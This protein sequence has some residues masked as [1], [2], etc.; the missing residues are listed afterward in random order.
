MWRRKPVVETDSYVIIP[1]NTAF[2]ELVQVA[3]HRLG[4]P[5]ESTSAA[6]GSVVIKNWKPLSFEKIAE[7]PTVTVGDILGELTTVATLRIQ[8]YRARPSILS[9]IK[10]KLL[11][12]LLA[13]SHGLLMS[14][15]CPLDE[16][17]LSH[18]CRTH[19]VP[20]THIPEPS[21]EC[22]RK[23]EQWWSLQLNQHQQHQHHGSQHHPMP[24]PQSGSQYSPGSGSHH[25][26]TP[27]KLLDRPPSLPESVHPALQ[28]VQSQYPTQKT[29]MRTS[30]DPELELPK[31]QRWF[32][33]NQH[34]SRQQIQQYVKELNGLE[35]RRGRKPLDI[36]NV[37]YW[38]KNARAAQKRAELRGVGPGLPCHISLNG[39]NSSS[40]SPPHT[41]S[42]MLGQEGLLP[43]GIKSPSTP[44][45]SPTR[46]HLF[47][48]D[49]HSENSNDPAVTSDQEDEDEIMRNEPRID[50]VDHRGDPRDD[51][52]AAEE[53]EDRGTGS[54]T[55]PL[56]LT[57]NDKDN[58][59]A[60][61]KSNILSEMD[62]IKQEPP[63]EVSLSLSSKNNNNNNNDSDNKN[64]EE[65][66]DMDEDEEDED[67][68]D[69]EDRRNKGDLEHDDEE[70]GTM[71]PARIGDLNRQQE[72]LRSFRSPSP[73]DMVVAARGPCGGGPP[74]LDRLA[75]AAAG[76]PLVPNSMFSHSIMYMSHYIPG[77]AHQHHGH[78]GLGPATPPSSSGGLNLSALAASADERRKRNRTFIDPV[79]EVPRLEQ[80]FSLNTHPSHNLI[81]KYTEE[82]NRM[83][84]RQKFPRLEPKNVQFWFKNR[85]AKCKRLK[86]SLFETPPSTT[87]V[88]HHQLTYHH[89]PGGDPLHTRD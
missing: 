20:G 27:N 38:F 59:E 12:L 61:P 70:I 58:A 25:T 64:C 11:R 21:E 55:G 77:L 1:V 42:M 44:L 89:S 16:L 17:T 10:D 65:I 60:S 56:S 49:H 84:Y 46:G 43:Q 26:S 79:T 31:L 88:N 6:R 39:Y 51:L 62:G 54:P 22:R 48:S 30:F 32:A 57:T 78:H 40:H 52:R 23:F 72:R 19:S 29:R 86:M 35:S 13:Q 33:E 63:D 69:L 41:G 47:L 87:A 4:Y 82:L 67:L 34:P 53:A 18:L 68:D 8:L 45:H 24:R 73:S 76:F 5:R 83:P 85:R 50:L 15:G 9:D 71:H 74:N 66:S 80:W 37:V 75:A 36:N 3:L 14:S 81:L 7:G 28:T 2:Q